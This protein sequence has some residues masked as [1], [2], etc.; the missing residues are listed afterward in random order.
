MKNQKI[1]LK[2]K[3]NKIKIT[4]P[5]VK[6]D[7]NKSFG[8]INSYYQKDRPN[9]F[10]YNSNDNILP[11][12]KKND[13]INYT[14]Y[15]S[16]SLVNTKPIRLSNYNRRNNPFEEE[17]HSTFYKT[18]HK[19]DLI[20]EYEGVGYRKNNYNY[21]ILK[22]DNLKY[23]F[24]SFHVKENKYKNCN[25]ES[26]S[27]RNEKINRNSK[28]NANKNLNDE[29][30]IT[31]IPQIISK[32]PGNIPKNEANISPITPI[33]KNEKIFSP[34]IPT[35]KNEKN[36]SSIIPVEKNEKNNSIIIPIKKN[37]KI[38]PPIISFPRSLLV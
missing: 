22:R 14:F 21:N 10:A 16:K 2:K 3:L 28:S 29:S 32:N 15:E 12:N 26:I 7:G 27:D 30:N 17:K 6:F 37:E 8:P 18:S 24:N 33:I 20:V 36:I 35:K 25:F 1:D 19:D 9:L 4:Y 5:E 34:I 11:S 38:I 23:R 13:K 31:K